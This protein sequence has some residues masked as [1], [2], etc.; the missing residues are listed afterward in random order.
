[1]DISFT[2]FL[3]LFKYGYTF[4][5]KQNFEYLDVKIPSKLRF[6]KDEYLSPEQQEQLILFKHNTFQEQK[7]KLST[8]TSFS[9][10]EQQNKVKKFIKISTLIKK[11]ENSNREHL[12]LILHFLINEKFLHEFPILQNFP[13]IMAYKTDSFKSIVKELSIAN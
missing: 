9:T 6:V 13:I 12:F 7:L 5:E 10:S 1:M 3:Q 8:L 11:L 4:F 2:K